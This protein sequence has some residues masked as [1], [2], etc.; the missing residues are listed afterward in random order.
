[1]AKTK[2][3]FGIS[4][5]PKSVKK[6]APPLL[7]VGGFPPRPRNAFPSLLPKAY[8]ADEVVMQPEIKPSTLRDSLTGKLWT[9]GKVNSYIWVPANICLEAMVGSYS[10]GCRDPE[11]S[12]EDIAGITIPPSDIIYPHRLGY[13]PGF[14]SPAPKFEQLQNNHI[15]GKYD[16]TIYNIVKFFHLC[17]NNNPNIV[18]ILFSPEHCITSMNSIGAHLIENRH[19]FLNKK[20]WHTFRGYA[21]GQLKKLS[22]INKNAPRRQEMIKKHGFDTKFA[23]HIV[24]LLLECEQILTTGDLILHKDADTYVA[25]RNGEWTRRRIEDFFFQ[26]EAEL[27]AL[28]K[29][30]TLLEK[31]NE[32]GIKKLLDECLEMAKVRS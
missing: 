24:R 3:V 15:D 27:E 6:P 2:S 17:M 20:C 8:P 28:Y 1:M 14:G 21:F 12:D 16:I 26:K 25:I 19:I 5:W 4:I 11:S 18:D 30:S 29:T 32:K 10:Y 13:I 23:Y 22:N 31:P 7:R 9:D